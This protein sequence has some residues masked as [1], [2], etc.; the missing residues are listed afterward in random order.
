[1]TFLS[2]TYLAHNIFIIDWFYLKVLCVIY[3]AVQ[4]IYIKFIS[5]PF[6]KY[7]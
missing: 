5:A 3:K 2:K 6:G 4:Y 7:N 1:M